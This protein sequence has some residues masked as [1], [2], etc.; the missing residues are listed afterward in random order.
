MAGG[1]PRGALQQLFP[2]TS[3][4]EVCKD[5]CDAHSWRDRRAALHDGISHHQLQQFPDTSRWTCTAMLGVLQIAR[6]EAHR[7]TGAIMC[8]KGV[9]RFSKC[10]QRHNQSQAKRQLQAERRVIRWRIAFTYL[11]L[12]PRGNDRRQVGRVR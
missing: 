1:G 10:T 7:R 9:P 2:E 3:S 8:T 11:Y 12:D 4:F 5:G 6:T